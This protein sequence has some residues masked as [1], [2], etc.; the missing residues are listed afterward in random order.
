MRG[1]QEPA[2]PLVPVPRLVHTPARHKL[3]VDGRHARTAAGQRLVV[4][5]H[6]GVSLGV[7]LVCAVHHPLLVCHRVGMEARAVKRKQVKRGRAVHNPRRH[8]ARQA[9]SQHHA[10]GVEAARVEHAANAGL[11]ADERLVIGCERL[12]SAH[13][14]LDAR[15]LDERAAVQVPRQVLSKRVPVELKQAEGECGVWRAPEF[16]VLLVP[17]D[18]KRIALRLEVDAEVVVA[19]IG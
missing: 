4:R 15:R 5:E 12:G 10:H 9:A 7:A 14:R 16:G 3:I 2:G 19:H 13:S 1:A 18:C 6:N 8:L 17:P 11:R